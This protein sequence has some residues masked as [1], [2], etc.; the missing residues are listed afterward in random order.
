MRS[1]WLALAMKSARIC[2]RR[3]CSVRSRKVTSTC[4][5][6]DADEPSSRDTVAATRRSTGTRS[7][8]ST[9]MRSSEASTRSTATSRSGLRETWLIGWPLLILGNIS[10]AR[11]L[12]CTNVPARIERQ[13]RRWNCIDDCAPRLA[14]G[15]RRAID[16]G[17][18]I[19][20]HRVDDGDGIERPRRRRQQQQ[21][22]Q[23][24]AR[25]VRAARRAAPAP[26]ECRWRQRS[27]SSVPPAVAW[28]PPKPC[29]P[30]ARPRPC[31]PPTARCSAPCLGTLWLMIG[32]NC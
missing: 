7:T 16:A 27:A 22:S 28:P 1:S 13:R 24:R 31:A 6:V 29:S 25:P 17:P 9:S 3:S 12:W 30:E 18:R 20:R 5:E 2:A 8:R 19:P 26:R 15:V 10:V 14:I 11:R 4:G 23:R 32:S 21:R